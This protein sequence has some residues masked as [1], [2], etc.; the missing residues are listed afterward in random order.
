MKKEKKYTCGA[1]NGYHRAKGQ[2]GVL[3]VD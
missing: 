2:I 1:G 3:L